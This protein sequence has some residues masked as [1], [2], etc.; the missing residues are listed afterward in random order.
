MLAFVMEQQSA[1]ERGERGPK[2]AVV[3]GTVGIGIMSRFGL[4]AA[5]RRVTPS[6]CILKNRTHLPAFPH[7]VFMGEYL[8]GYSERLNLIISIGRVAF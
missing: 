4:Y 6:G 7:S 8:F 2:R 1:A 3:T 5:R